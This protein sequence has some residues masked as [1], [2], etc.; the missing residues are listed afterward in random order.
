MIIRELITTL[1]FKF[2]PAAFNKYDTAIG[3]LYAKTDKLNLN[4]RRLGDDI[5]RVGQSLT[6]KLTLPIIGVGAASVMAAGQVEDMTL[7]FANFLGSTEKATA[8][9]KEL[10]AVSRRSGFKIQSVSEAA[11]ALFGMGYAADEAVAAMDMLSNVAV[12]AKKDLVEVVRPFGKVMTTGKLS[13]RELMAF[14]M[15]GIDLMD[16][17]RKSTGLTDDVL[18]EMFTKGKINAAMV[19]DAFVK[20]TSEGGRFYKLAE[21][22]DSS[23]TGAFGDIGDAIYRV[24]AALGKLIIENL[25]L[26]KV[27]AKIAQAL[28]DFADSVERMPKWLQVVLGLLAMIAAAIGP[29]LMGLGSMIKMTLMIQAVSLMAGKTIIGVLAGISVAAIEITLTVLAVAA[30]LAAI[31][32]I[33]E[34]I[35]SYY[36][37]RESYF[38]DFVNAI[39]KA[40]K[41]LVDLI[42]DMLDTIK[43]KWQDFIDFIKMLWDSFMDGLKAIGAQFKEWFTELI[44][45]AK[46]TIDKVPFLKALFGGGVQAQITNMPPVVAGNIFSGFTPAVAASSFVPTYAGAGTGAGMQINVDSNFV[47]QVPTGTTEQQMSAWNLAAERHTDELTAKIIDDIESAK[48]R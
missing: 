27:F 14:Q 39:K 32:L 15:A 46:D 29:I 40:I 45:W 1:G 36:Q 30:A 5:S 23:T 10:F 2:D 4:L 34:D 43:Q 37:G 44:Q 12:G 16:E 35:V 11:V 21:K 9:M 25:H 8:Y 48:K 28:E 22:L 18:Q 3:S 20:M 19:R 31:F 47:F 42:T 17:L 24:R 38:G 6:W 33:V 7:V 26:G 41:W 13:Q